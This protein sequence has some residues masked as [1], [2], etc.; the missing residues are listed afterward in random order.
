MC[1]FLQEF[2][3]SKEYCVLFEK[4]FQKKA[5]DVI[6]RINIKFFTNSESFNFCL[7]CDFVMCTQFTHVLIPNYTS[8]AVQ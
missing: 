4:V 7:D 8:H 5:K 3:C 6:L 1:R 2:T